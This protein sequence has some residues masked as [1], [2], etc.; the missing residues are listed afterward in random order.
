MDQ[1]VDSFI[2]S[3]CQAESE[4]A[5]NRLF[6]GH[7]RDLGYQAYDAYR[8]RVADQ[9]AMDD[10]GNFVV[11]SYDPG[12]LEPYLKSGMAEMC[13]VL[14]RLS[15]AMTPFDYIAFLDR[16]PTSSS[17][18]WQRR[19]LDAFLVRH[20]WCI[21]LNTVSQV[22]GVTLYMAGGKDRLT[23]FNASRH[24]ATLISAYY[25]EALESFRPGPSGIRQVDDIGVEDANS[26]LSAREIDCLHWAALGRSNPEI[27]EI[28]TV[29]SN[30]V[31]FHMKNAFRKLGVSSR[32]LAVSRAQEMGLIN[33]NQ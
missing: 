21:P 8:H 17:V 10:P 22:K 23:E 12:L 27:G 3:A 2:A 4:K 33:Q 14:T 24:V 26:A 18:Q 5:L 9:V 25:F 28:L 15:E 29:S 7:I 16:L 31:R 30:T 20:A 1:E 13:P 19:T 32:I 6:L 11:A